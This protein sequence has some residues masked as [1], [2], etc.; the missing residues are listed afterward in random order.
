MDRW[1]VVK[2]LKGTFLILFTLVDDFVPLPRGAGLPRARKRWKLTIDS[3]DIG[4]F[5]EFW[6]ANVS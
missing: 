6:R 2:K 1:P 5:V 4:N 3:R